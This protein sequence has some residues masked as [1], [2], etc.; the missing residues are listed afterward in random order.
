MD[1]E[2]IIQAIVDKLE[3][4]P[5]CETS[6]V[7]TALCRVGRKEFNC[8]VY[9]SSRFVKRHEKSGGEWLYDVTWCEIDDMNYTRSVPVAAEC[10]WKNKGDIYD[11]FQKLLL[12]RVAVR[13]FIY[14][15]IHLEDAENQFCEW[16]RKYDDRQ[17]GDTYFFAGYIGNGT[18]WHFKYFKIVVNKVNQ[19]DLVRYD[20]I[21]PRQAR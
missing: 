18:D 17:N 15:E 21:W 6:D 11:D 9:A 20:K 5:E 7:L 3:S 19:T 2:E 13:V 1:T 10:E 8:S 12:A 16:I 4:L 14:N